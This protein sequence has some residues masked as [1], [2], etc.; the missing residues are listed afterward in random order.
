M[1]SDSIAAVPIPSAAN[2]K[3]PGKK[4]RTN[5]SAKLKQY[6][7]DARREQWLSQG[8]VKSKGC[9]DG[10]DD[11]GQ[12]PPSP[13]VK[14]G[15][16]ALEPLDTRRRGEEDDGL[17]HHDS[18]SE[19]PA[20]CPTGVLCGNDSGTN[21]TGSSSGGQQQQQQFQQ[22]RVLFRERHRGG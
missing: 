13:A 9:R 10:V 5:R 12:A 15:K 11:D 3:N 22:W 19:F 21:F 4:K 17:I 20:N 16:R 2:T 1:V 8:T 14:H 7:I 18:D 6:K